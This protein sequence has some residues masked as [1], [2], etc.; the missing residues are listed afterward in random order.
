MPFLYDYVDVTW[1]DSEKT[2]IYAE[3]DKT[4]AFYSFEGEVLEY[5]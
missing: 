2:E 5:K 3:L 4:K 1:T